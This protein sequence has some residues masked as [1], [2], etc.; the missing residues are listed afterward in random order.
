MI[1]RGVFMSA[2]T[3]ERVLKTMPCFFLGANSGGGF[4]SCFQEIYHPREGERLYILK[5]GPGTGKS[6]FMKKL[7]VEMAGKGIDCQ[8]FFC[9][10]DP[11]SLDGIR[12]PSL[13][14]ALVD[15]TAPHV[16]EAKYLGISERLVD[17][18][19]ALDC[20]KLGSK[21][22]ELLP[23]FD[24]NAGLHQRASRFLN[25]ASQLIND[26]FIADCECTDM[27][28]AERSAL[29]IC[30]SY[31]PA[32]NQTGKETQYFLS[33]ITPDGFMFYE[34]TLEKFADKIVA[35]EDEYG[36]TASVMMS[37]I[38]SY[39]LSSGY[40]IITCPCALSPQR[41]I[42]HI[43]VPE[44]GMAFCTTNWFLPLTVDTQRRIH[45]RR[46][47]DMEAIATR[48]QRLRFNRR[49]SEELLDGACHYI[50]E[51]RKVHDQM[52]EYYIQGMDFSLLDQKCEEVLRELEERM[53]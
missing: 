49:A 27:E 38:R 33:G 3:F 7:A 24:Q 9:S 50:H 30:K 47:R 15:G 34:Q 53:A 41:K 16:M 2:A 21:A 46:F 12:F 44:K 17:L 4:Y 20:K 37:V 36:A 35:V 25:A 14:A 19:Q 11:N 10:S 8:L 28:K 23:L 48:K 52:E 5:G 45:A 39:L 31:F 22:K 13:K 18:G 29:R 32:K 26:S 43:I 51:A 1:P 40:D 42:D 6:T